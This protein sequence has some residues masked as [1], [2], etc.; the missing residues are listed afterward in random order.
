MI[1]I[2]KNA[3]KKIFICMTICLCLFSFSSQAQKLSDNERKLIIDELKE[4]IRIISKFQYDSP[5]LIVVYNS[6]LANAEKIIER[7]SNHKDDILVYENW[8]KLKTITAHN[9]EIIAFL[10]PKIVDWSYREG[11]AEL[12]SGNGTRAKSN[13]QKALKLNPQHV[14]TN[15]QLARMDIDSIKLGDAANRL[16]SVLSTMNPTQDEKDLIQ[17]ILTYAYN[18]N[19]MYALNLA[20]QEK[21]AQ[22]VAV[23]QELGA[24]CVQDKLQICNNEAIATTLERCQTGVYSTQI[25][26]AKKALKANR[27][28]AAESFA[29]AAYEY[30]GNNQN[31]IRDNNDFKILAKLIAESYIKDA[32]ELDGNRKAALLMEYLGKAQQM[33]DYTEA[34][35]K[36]LLNAKIAVLQP[37]KSRLELKQES[38][39]QSAIDTSYAEKFKE[40]VLDE[41][42]EHVDNNIEVKNIE[43]HYINEKTKVTQL[44]TS[45]NKKS[46]SK[47]I[48]DK[49][50]ETRSFLSV[51][52]FE[53]ALEVLE[54]AN[55]LAKIEGEKE[56]VENMY[57]LAIREITAKRMSAAEYAIWQGE[58]TVA[59]SLINITNKLIKSYQMEKDT[60]IVR[61]MKSYLTA[62]DK[63]VCDKRQEELNGYIYNIMD[64]IRRKDYY[65]AEAYVRTAL[66]VPESKNCKLDK[67]KLK[68]LMQQI[69]KPIEY[70]DVM[71]NAYQNLKRGDTNGYVQ[72]YS[73]AEALFNRYEL[74]MVGIEHTPMRDVLANMNDIDFAL[75]ALEIMVKY[76]EYMVA[77]ES[78]S[79]IK[80]MGYKA[81]Q[82]KKIQDR[83]AKLMSYDMSKQGYNYNDAIETISFYS[84]DKWYK[85]Y[86]KAFKKYMKT[87]IKERSMK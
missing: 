79:A 41:D 30:Y 58:P 51:N 67:S 44:G 52:S 27:N 18:K 42:I 72:Q 38:I 23:L 49:F 46:F 82:T 66:S 57:R 71:D 80:A 19:Y 62:L 7:Y 61:I 32:S 4:N 83:L 45:P 70:I 34:N 8:Y 3:Q 50:Y 85:T 28:A 43:Q 81:S 68:S 73:T 25:A 2:I 48:D 33:A 60:A 69:E 20:N 13:F 9:K 55:Q 26:L 36:E 74:G 76:K 78:L 5:E 10:Q 15:Y 47:A 54:S 11:I 56:E 84:A 1:S 35:T 87:W 24:F 29:M 17:S 21:Y 12:E 65:K 63:K 14:L 31:Y 75:N 86:S 53:K 22:A 59:D 77:L 39:E 37:Q 16:F 64:C 6:Q 40:Y